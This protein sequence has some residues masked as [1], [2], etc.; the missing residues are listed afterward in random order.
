MDRALGLLKFFTVDPAV[1]PSVRAKMATYGLCKDEYNRS[2][3]WMSQLYVRTAL[4]MVGRRVLTQQDVVTHEFP[5]ELGDS[6][7]V[8]AY[9]VDIP[10]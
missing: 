2:Q 3:H 5:S 10:G 1:S 6:I 9:T 7:G 8:G 4:R